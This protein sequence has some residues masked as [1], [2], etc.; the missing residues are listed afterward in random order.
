MAK[1]LS[2]KTWV[3]RFP[4]TKTTAS[5]ANDFRP[6]CEAFIAAMRSAGATVTVSSTRRPAER[7][8]LMHFCWR[9]FK[10]TSNPQNVPAKPGV[11]IEWVHRKPDDSADLPASRAAAKAMVEGYGIAFAPALHSRHTEGHA[12]D[13]TIEWTG[14]LVIAS[15]D[16]SKT[17]ITATP[18]N[19]F[20]AVLRR[21]GK[22]YGVTKNPSDPPHWSTD[23]R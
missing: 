13:M 14:N 23:G 5:L 8:Y 21:V 18:R 20:N 19:G 2:G 11:D 22:T 6:G 4:D 17:T 16:G 3:A 9:I 12:I 7:A 1:E 15:R 10:Q